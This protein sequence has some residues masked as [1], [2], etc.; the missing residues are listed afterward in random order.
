MFRRNLAYPPR[1]GRFPRP[2]DR[3]AYTSM[4]SGRSPAETSSMRGG[5]SADGGESSRVWH[6]RVRSAAWRGFLLS[7]PLCRRLLPRD[8]RRRGVAWRRRFAFALRFKA[9]LLA[10]LASRSR[11][12]RTEAAVHRYARSSSLATSPRS[13]NHSIHTS[14]PPRRRTGFSPHCP[15]SLGQTKGAA[16]TGRPQNQGGAES[17]AAERTK[18]THRQRGEVREG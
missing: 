7:R 12:A 14:C 18:E 15:A 3:S 16:V 9:S 4:P 1:V 17:A 10:M 11:L 13:T 2:C 8:P 6:F 5:R